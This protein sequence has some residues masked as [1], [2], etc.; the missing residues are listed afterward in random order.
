MNAFALT[1][2]DQGRAAGEAMPHERC[3]SALADAGGSRPAA[4]FTR[5]S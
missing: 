5:L 3:G 1:E 4:Y 2:K